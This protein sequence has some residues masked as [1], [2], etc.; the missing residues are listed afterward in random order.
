[1]RIILAICLVALVHSAEIH[2][3]LD[4]FDLNPDDVQPLPPQPTDPNAGAV[5][6]SSGELKPQPIIFDLDPTNAPSA[7]AGQPQQT[8]GTPTGATA[9][10]FHPQVE[11]FM[12][13]PMMWG[14]PAM[15][16]MVPQQQPQYQ[17]QQ[18]PVQAPPAQQ[19]Q[20]QPQLQQSSPQRSSSITTDDWTEP[21]GWNWNTE[22]NVDPEGREWHRVQGGPPIPL[23]PN[24]DTLPLGVD[25]NQDGKISADEIVHLPTDNHQDLTRN[26]APS[27]TQ[28][29]A[30]QTYTRP[31][32]QQYAQAAPTQQVAQTSSQGL[33]DNYG[34]LLPDEVP[35]ITLHDGQGERQWAEDPAY[36]L[37]TAPS[38]RMGYTDADN[39]F[40]QPQAQP[41]I[42]Q[43]P[44]QQYTQQRLQP[45][46][47]APASTQYQAP[48]TTQYQAPATTQYQA[49]AQ[50]TPQQGQDPWDL[51]G[52]RYN[53]HEE[54]MDAYYKQLEELKQKSENGG[55]Q[56]NQGA[57]ATT[58]APTGTTTP[59]TQGTDL[60]NLPVHPNTNAYTPTDRRY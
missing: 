28:T 10:K 25:W 26:F 33:Y 17:P 42:Q 54:A 31:V 19:Y 27:Q 5:Q 47:Q 2:Y 13:Q 29:P 55:F 22:T 6:P 58:T 1:M 57:P 32:T 21:N 3:D 16:F 15:E 60:K 9:H 38:W 4:I 50:T 12:P 49:P 7:T 8:G 37:Q 41:Q 14:Y 30:A 51:G 34:N 43:A 35:E 11:V 56:T 59:A 23:D 20:P 36:Q 53:T 18:Q 40:T 45:Q 48:A 24:S 46:Y 39:Q 52:T 44:P